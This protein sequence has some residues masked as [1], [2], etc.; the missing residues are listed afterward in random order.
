MLHPALP[1]LPRLPRLPPNP[2]LPCLPRLYPHPRIGV[3][4]FPRS[5]AADVPWTDL[6]TQ[7][8]AVASQVVP[9]APPLVVVCRRG[10]NSQFAVQWLRTHAGI[11]AVDVIGGLRAW[12]ADVDPAFPLY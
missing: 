1:V 8:A 4:S 9:A 5:L 6:P 3:P 12:S 11:D 2:R 10:N 7:W